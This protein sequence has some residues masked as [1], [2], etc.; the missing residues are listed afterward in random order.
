[1]KTKPFSRTTSP[2]S[3]RFK[4]LILRNFVSFYY[5]FFN[6]VSKFRLALFRLHLKEK[7]LLK[8]KQFENFQSVSCQERRCEKLCPFTSDRLDAKW[9]MLVG[10]CVSGQNNTFLFK[11]NVNRLQSIWFARCILMTVKT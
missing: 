10:S 1:M 6:K 4:S 7:V 9:A 5:L 11:N 3:E 8:K 2:L